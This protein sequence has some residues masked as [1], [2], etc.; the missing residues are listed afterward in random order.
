MGKLV[1][2]RQAGGCRSPSFWPATIPYPACMVACQKM[3]EPVR[4][5]LLQPYRLD[6]THIQ[7]TYFTPQGWIQ[8]YI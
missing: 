2:F 5:L 1:R 8:G 7:T 6:T 4:S 3:S